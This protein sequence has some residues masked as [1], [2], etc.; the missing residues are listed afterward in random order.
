MLR[1][2]GF[3]FNVYDLGFWVEGLG[4][5]FKILGSGGV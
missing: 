3:G 5:G 1:V 4:K 2:S